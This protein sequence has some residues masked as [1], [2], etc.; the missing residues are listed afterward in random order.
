MAETKLGTCRICDDCC[1][2]RT[3]GAAPNTRDLC[4]DCT[5]EVLTEAF[6]VLG[7]AGIHDVMTFVKDHP[8][9]SS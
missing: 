5:V 2:V 8:K 9:K 1:V 6:N 3:V 4:T 7:A